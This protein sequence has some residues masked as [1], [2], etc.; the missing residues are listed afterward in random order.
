M[1]KDEVKTIDI[2]KLLVNPSNP[3]F[4]DVDS[5]NEA[6]KNIIQ[7]NP[8]KLIKLA[9]DIVENGLNPIDLPLVSPHPDKEGYYIVEE[10]N[11]RITAIKLLLSPKLSKVDENSNKLYLKFKDLSQ[12]ID[13]N[14]LK[15]IN[16]VVSVNMESINHWIK[17]KHTG[18]NKGAG[19][20]SWT[21]EQKRR[22]EQKRLGITSVDVQIL[23]FI[24]S[25][26]Y[27]RSTI[28]SVHKSNLKRLIEDPNVKDLLGIKKDK[29]ILKTNI[30]KEELLKGL[31]KIIEDL[32]T[33]RIN[34]KDIYYKTDRKRYL[35]TFDESNIPD[36]SLVFED[37]IPLNALLDESSLKRKV[38]V[39]QG[40]LQFDNVSTPPTTPSSNH[41]FV[42][43]P[44]ISDENKNTTSIDTQSVDTNPPNKPINLRSTPLPWT[45][46]TLI[47][48]GLKL[49]IPVKRI[50]YIYKELQTLNVD[51]FPN[52]AA[53][54]FRVFL[55]LS[56]D[57][58]IEEKN[59]QSCSRDAKLS[60][61]IQA[62]SEFMKSN[63]ILEK[64]DLKPVNL[65]VSSQDSLAST[66]TL[67][68][69]VHNP[70]IQPI[71]KD[72]KVAWDNI[73]KFI[74]ALWN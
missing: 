33:K 19:T 66:N 67:N 60:R 3:R 26:G 39:E 17:L 56:I 47:P 73:E 62:V 68:S 52:S 4:E 45:R 15:K 28:K 25:V 48:K 8:D 21:P 49:K 72:L 42:T 53:V 10:G 54:L 22:F 12:H 70:N 69:Y 37:Y 30:P 64:D 41:D 7:D 50:N 65:I 6:I 57:N 34:V 55:E 74:K 24:E 18:E 9:S 51:E 35:S 29:G 63:E 38:V 71:P 5:E 59:I 20:V 2:N 58:Y 46:K 43:K 11:R 13:S 27:P 23:D 40:N 1:S 31:D 44:L 16:C 36:K 14:E 61:K 32:S